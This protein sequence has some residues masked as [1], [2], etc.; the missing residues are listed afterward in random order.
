MRVICR[1]LRFSRCRAHHAHG[2]NRR[3]SAYPFR[4]LF[5]CAPARGFTLIELIITLIIVGVLAAVVAPR[6]SG[7]TAFSARGYADQIES[8]LRF[9]Q[10]TA[11]A[12]RRTTRLELVDCTLA[13]GACDTAPRLCVA[14]SWAA[15]AACAR[16]GHL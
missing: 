8:Y 14:Q 6:F 5:R 4:P 1:M 13:S 16:R 3:V 10:K 11:V 7:L 15:T 12:A 2:Y 9:A